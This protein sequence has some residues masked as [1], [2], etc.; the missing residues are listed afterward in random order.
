[1]LKELKT[2]FAQQAKH[3]LLQTTRYFQSCKQEE[4]QSVSSYVLK[5]KGYIDNLEHLG[6]PVTLSL[7][8]ELHAMLKLHE[9][10]LPKNNAPAFHAIRA[11]KVQKEIEAEAL[12]LYVGNGQREAIKAIGVFYLCLPSELEIVLKNCHYAPSITRGVISISYLYE[13]GFIN[14][15]VNNT[16]QVSRNNIVYFSAIPRDGIFEIDLS[17]SYT[18]KSFMYA[19][20]NKRA[21][22]DLESALLWH[23]RLGHISKKRIEKLQHDGLLNS[24][25]LRAFE[26]CVPCM[27]R[28]MARKPYTYQ[29][30][31]AKELL[32]LIHTDVCGPFKSMSRQGANYFITFTKDF[33]RY[34]YVYLLKHKNVVFEIFK[35]FQKEVENQLGKTIRSLRSDRAGKYISQEFLDHLKGHRIIAHRTPPYTPQHNKVLERRNI[36]LLDMVEKTPYEVWHEQA[37][38]LS[39]LKVWG[40]EA[41]VKRDTLTKPD[42]LKPRSIKCIFI[43]YPK[44]TMGYS[45]YYPHKNKVLVVRNVKFLKNSLIT[46][47]ASGSLEDLEIIQKKYTHPSIDTS[48][49][50]KEDDLEID[51][52]QSDIIPIRR[53]TRTCR[54]TDH[55]CL[56]I[57]AE[58]HELGDL[59]EPAN[60]KAALLDP[61]K[62]LFKKKTDMDGAVH[63]YKARL[64]AKGYTQTLW[65]DYEETFS[66]VADIRAIRILITITAYYDY[67]IWQMDIKTAFLNGYLNEEVYVE[68]PK[69]ILM[70]N[71]KRRSIPMQEKLRLSKSQG[72][73]TP[74]ELKRMQ[75]VPYALA[76]PGDLRWTTVKNI[77]KY[78][79]NTKI[80]YVFI[81]NGSAIDWKSTKKSIF[82]T[83][84]V[85]AKYITAFDAS[86][87][88]VWVRKFISRLGVVLTFKEPQFEKLVNTSRAKNLIKSHD[89]LALVAHTGSSSIN[90]SSY[91]VTHPTSVVDYDDEYQQD[92]I[93]TNYEDPLTSEVTEGSNETGNVQRTLQNSSLGNTSTVQCYNYSGKGHYVRNYLKPR[94]QD[95]KYFMEQILLAKQDEAEVILT[96]EQNEFLFADALRMKEIKDL[97]ANVCLMARIQPTNHSSDVGL[98]YDFAFVRNSLQ[99]M[100]I[101]GPKPLS[102]YDQQLKHGLRYS[103]PYTL[104]QIMRTL[105]MM[106]PKA[107]KMKEKLN[108]PIVV[109]NKQNCWIVGYQPINALY[110][111]FVPQKEL[112]D[113]QKY[114]PSSFIISAKNSKE[115]TSI[116]ASMPRM[117]ATSSV[118]RS[119]N[120][121]SHDKNSVLAH[122]KN[123]TK[124]VVVYVRKNKQTYN[125]FPNVISN[126]ENVIDVDVAIDSKEKNLLCVSCMQNVLILCHDKCLAHHRLNASRTLTTKSRTLKSS[127]TT[128]VVLKTRFSEKSSQ[129][130]TLDTTSVVSK[131]K[132][133]V[134]SASKA[135]NKVSSASKTNRRDLR[136]KSLSSYIKNKIRTSRI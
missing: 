30:E 130:K 80:G 89:P 69:A 100:I 105:L 111:D 114:F 38:K 14:R 86:K 91:Y 95:S 26:K 118:R 31:R 104:K 110:K 62:W 67:E 99:G 34:G 1:M 32:G 93:Q 83:S 70:E 135:K 3:E 109:V 87:E 45:F 42:K 53:S 24:I 97:S 84:Y 94:V 77:M 117:N 71:S 60:Y 98:S 33:S 22:I 55:M 5:M 75:N 39:Y 126:K 123:S 56:Y 63:T 68:Q 112:S 128:F 113:E 17:N 48:L 122:S 25:D 64:V 66:P 15:F 96:D 65:I 107:N 120:R 27:S 2:L 108:D 59:G 101:L 124:Q 12:S 81:L 61:D 133:D 115:T 74:A 76:N 21:K 47:K 6:H 36:T 58:E 73:S 106:L 10:T 13:D 85:E 16:I 72:A 8:N 51:E 134:G 78:L 40:C 90:T 50:H 43:G 23:C 41:L 44:E 131:S 125:T 9:Q 4:G 37:P 11:G 28:M 52:P 18:N 35:V 102:V 20:S 119:M 46:Q 7:D 129:S 29:V 103:N 132:I 127:N 19:V 79:K 82:A 136:N 49:N 57:D 54:P 92:D 88:V 116:P 121:D